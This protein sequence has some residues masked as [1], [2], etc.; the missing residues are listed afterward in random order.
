MIKA[1]VKTVLAVM[2][3]TGLPAG[4]S[5]AQAT[6]EAI[7]AYL[8]LP[9]PGADYPFVAR[10]IDVQEALKAYARNLRIGLAADSAITGIVTA[11]LGRGLSRRDYLA[12]LALEF[13]F[14][15]YFDGRVLRVSPVGATT[16]EIMPL[17]NNSG[18]DVLRILKEL[19]IYQPAFTHRS[20]LRNR[21][22]LVSGPAEYVTLVKKAIEAIEAADRTKITVLR[23]SEG[24]VPPALGALQNAETAN[25]PA[26]LDAGTSE[27]PSTP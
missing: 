4:A 19:D 1:R 18:A 5:L 12:A 11:D 25:A 8:S 2:A 27:G 21:T 22:F 16:T 7:S 10:G 17:Q 6:E 3:L 24:S 14:A 23:G 15:W 13:D 9:D 26:G 20:D